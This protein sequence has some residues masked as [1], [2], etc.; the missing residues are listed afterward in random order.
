MVADSEFN[1]DHMNECY[2]CIHKRAV[3]G[4]AHIEC[5]KWSEKVSR[6]GESYGKKMGWFNYPSCF[7]P[8]WKGEERCENF[9]AKEVEDEG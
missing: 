3:P 8:V 5:L 6:G 4:N 2:S 9:Q 1:L 7:D